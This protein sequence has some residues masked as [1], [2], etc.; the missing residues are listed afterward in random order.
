M[1][2][3][4]MLGFYN[5]HG[6]GDYCFATISNYNKLGFGFDVGIELVPLMHLGFHGS[7]NLGLA[8]DGLVFSFFHLG[9]ILGSAKGRWR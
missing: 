4:Y 2:E 1:I 7:P 6:S 5:L 9:F 3:P 8:H